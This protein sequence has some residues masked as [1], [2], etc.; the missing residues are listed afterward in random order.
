MRY[1][2][3]GMYERLWVHVVWTT[4]NRAHLIDLQRASLLAARLPE[5]ALRERARIEEIGIVMTHLHLLIRLHPTT[6]IPRLLQRMKGGSAR[7]ANQDPTGSREPLRWAKGYSLTP[8]SPRS[9]QAAVAYIRTQAEH[10]PREAI[11]GWEERRR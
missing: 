8:V 3:A 6:L 9:I 11:T 1:Q 4:R 10:H 5:I 7:E 2:T